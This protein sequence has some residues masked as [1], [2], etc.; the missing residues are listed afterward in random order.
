M[1]ENF[2]KIDALLERLKR[3]EN[4]E[5]NVELTNELRDTLNQIFPQIYCE[6]IRINKNKGWDLYG[7]LV[8]PTTEEMKTISD[9]IANPLFTDKKDELI[10][11]RKIRYEIE[12]DNMILN[13]QLIKLS[14][15]ELCALLLYE[16][17]HI[18]NADEYFG[19]LGLVFHKAAIDLGYSFPTK[20]EK[21]KRLYLELSISLYLYDYM[22]N[23]QILFQ[24]KYNRI[25]T[26]DYDFVSRYDY[27][28][29]LETAIKSISIFYTSAM[30]NSNL[31]NFKRDLMRQARV[32]AYAA[33]N[34]NKVRNFVK[35][36]IRIIEK[37]CTSEMLRERLTTID[38]KLKDLLGASIA[39]QKLINIKDMLVDT[40]ESYDSSDIAMLTLVENDIE[41]ILRDI[42]VINFD[43]DKMYLLNKSYFCL[44]R[45]D[46]IS[47]KCAKKDKDEFE[48]KVE[49]GK[50][51][52][53]KLI[54]VIIHKPKD[55]TESY[56]TIKSLVSIR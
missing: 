15:S 54:N 13:D 38:Y 21:L 44:S 3:A 55:V 53:R 4:Q 9:T 32:F 33:E 40:L 22:V 18:V 20:D 5:S 1:N 45:L 31:D 2:V 27:K 50:D 7:I 10:T 52:V 25:N 14:G 56:E 6:S 48:K 42:Q 28:E 17:S 34:Y 43:K 29:Y 24:I 39:K 36:Q 11:P 30:S 26:D 12:M 47:R 16:I 49:K 46:E 51:C 8:F 19:Q 37:D 35:E 23:N 41:D